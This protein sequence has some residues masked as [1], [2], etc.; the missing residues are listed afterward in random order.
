MKSEQAYVETCLKSFKVLEIWIYHVDDESG[1][2]YVYTVL[3]DI[4]KCLWHAK[5]N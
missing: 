3:L 2:L 5:I 1:W 4:F